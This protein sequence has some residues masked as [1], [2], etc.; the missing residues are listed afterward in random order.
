MKREEEPFYLGF[1]AGIEGLD[2]RLCPYQKITREWYEWQRWHKWGIELAW[3][4]KP[5]SEFTF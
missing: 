3:G 1:Q 2:P 4:I 5:E